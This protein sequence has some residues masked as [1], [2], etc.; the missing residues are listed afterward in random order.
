MDRMK[1]YRA[2]LFKA[3]SSPL[4]LAIIDILR[5]KE[6]GVKEIAAAVDCEQGHISQQ[7]SVLRSS[8]I[9]KY[10]KEGNYVYYS[11]ADSSVLNLLDEA[12][13]FSRKRISDLSLFL[14][15]LSEVE[16]E[17]KKRYSL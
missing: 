5:D 2:E 17:D 3:L 7:L 8:G 16:A 15:K 4:R 11:I 6:Y 10:R 1:E 9:V 13:L 12:N 14:G